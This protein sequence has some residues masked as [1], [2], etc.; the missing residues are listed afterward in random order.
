MKSFGVRSTSNLIGVHKDLV[1]VMREAIKN[2]PHDFTITQGLRTPAQQKELFDKGASR[3]LMSR[4]LTGHAVDIAIIKDGKAVWDFKLYQE[5]AGHIKDVAA[6]MG[7]SLVWGGDFRT[8]KDGVHFELS[9][10][11]Y[12]PK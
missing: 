4:H 12:P 5:V 1:N 8:L 3:T 6:D 2:S 10:K 11:E 9:R 7:V